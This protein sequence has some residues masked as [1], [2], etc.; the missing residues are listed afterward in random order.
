[1]GGAYKS[2]GGKGGFWRRLS[3]EKPCPTLPASP[4]QKATSICHPDETRPLSVRE[5]A[6]VQQFPDEYF[7]AGPTS[8]KYVQIGNAVPVGLAYAVGATVEKFCQREPV[9]TAQAT[10]LN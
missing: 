7:L 5:Y 2:S 10:Q 8:S 3:S 4:I 6:G 1:M 9:F